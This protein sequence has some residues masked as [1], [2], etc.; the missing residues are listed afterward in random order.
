MGDSP[1][2]SP[3]LDR[4]H[5]LI[6]EWFLRNVGTPTDIQE[7]AWP[8]IAGGEHVLVSA[9]TGSGKTLT[10]FLWAVNQMV[11][12]EWEVGRGIRALYI[13]PLKALNNDINRNLSGPL[14][15]LRQTFEAA[16]EPFPNIRVMTRSGDTP[17]GERSR[18]L[19]RPPDILITTPESLN[20]L[21]TSRRGRTIFAP[22]NSL[23]LSSD[24]ATGGAD[25]PLAPRIGSVRTVILDEIHAVAGS[26]RGTHLITAIERLTELTGEFQRIALS[27]TVRPLEA[28][29]QFVGGYEL[30]SELDS[31][32]HSELDSELQGEGDHLT[33]A[34][35]GADFDFR[36]RPV[37]I[38]ETRVP[39]RI[40]IEVRSPEASAPAFVNR[41]DSEHAPPGS[42]SREELREDALEDVPEE[43]AIWIALAREFTQIIARNRS[44]LFF[45]NSRRLAEKMTRLI[46]QESGE[47]LALCHHGSL[48]REIRLLVE[49]RLKSGALRAIVAT[50]SLELGIDIGSVDEVVM[51]QTPRSVAQTLQRIGRAGH[52]VGQT[53][54]GAIYPA[55]NR[56]V[57]DAALMARAVLE[58]AIEPVR[59]PR[60]PLDVIAQVI[61][62]MVANQERDIEEVYARIR[63][64][65][66]CHGLERRAFD[67]VLEMLA[68]RY[69]DS[70]IRELRPRI[71]ID[72]VRGRIR[73]RENVER[74]LYMSGGTIPDRGYFDLRVSESNAKIGQL[75]EEF[76]WERAVGEVFSLGNHH[77]KIVDITHN[78]VLVTA[79]DPGQD[80]AIVPFW[81]ADQEDRGGHFCDRL[82]DFLE[83]AEQRLQ[84]AGETA[85]G[86]AATDA[87]GETPPGIAHA[88]GVF[89][90][91][92]AEIH[93]GLFAELQQNYRL[94]AEPAARLLQWL[95]R[96]REATGV[97][98]PGRRNLVVEY[99]RD[100]AGGGERLQVILH[101]FWGGRCNRPLALAFQAAWLEIHGESI[102]AIHNDDAVMLILPGEVPAVRLFGM[103]R[104][105]R[106]EEYLRVTLEPGGFFGARFRENAGRALLLP[107][108]GFGQRLPLWLN[109]LR[110]K[111]LL[112]AIRRYRD[113]PIL[114]ETWRSCFQESFEIDR[115]R[116]LLEDVQSGAIELSESRTRAASPFAADLVWRD[117]NVYMY[118]DDAARS[119]AG[120]GENRTTL[121]EQL[122]QEVVFS[123]ERRPRIAEDLRREFQAKLQRTAPGYAP[124]APVE[125][126]EWVK[127]R[128]LIPVPEWQA[129]L[130]SI[131]RD[132]SEEGGA[133]DSSSDAKET[134]KSGGDS[135]GQ[136]HPRNIEAL[137]KIV[138]EDLIVAVLPG[139]GIPVVLAAETLGRI[140][141]DLAAGAEDSESG[142]G[143]RGLIAQFLRYYGPVDPTILSLCFGF[144]LTQRESILKDLADSRAIVCAPLRKENDELC[145]CD[146]ENLESLLRMTRRRARPQIPAL[147]AR[148]LPAFLAEI[149]KVSPLG[150]VRDLPA[151]GAV[152]SQA[153]VI[154]IEKENENENENE[155]SSSGGRPALETLQ[156]VLEQLMGYPAEPGAWEREILP[157]RVSPYYTSF[158]DTL[159][160]EHD[161]VWFGCHHSRSISSNKKKDVAGKADIAFAFAEDLELY[162]L[163]GAMSSA[164]GQVAELKLSRDE[165]RLFSAL[166]G[167]PRSVSELYSRS[168]LEPETLSR[169][170]WS[171]A[172]RGL[173]SSD[174]FGVVRRGVLGRF[175]SE[176]GVAGAGRR[177]F[178]GAG[179]S[180]GW[181]RG[182]TR[183]SVRSGG[184]W[185]ALH[186]LAGPAETERDLYY[187][188]GDGSGETEIETEAAGD[189]AAF[190]PEPDLL[191]REELIRERVRILFARYGVL[192]R[193]LLANEAP[194]LRWS[195]VFRQL[196]LMEL[197]GEILGGYFFEGVPGLQFISPAANRLLGRGVDR[198]AVYGLSAKD[199]ASL[200]GIKSRNSNFRDLNFPE[201]K[202]GVHFVF[203]GDGGAVLIVRRKLSALEILCAPEDPVLPIA[204]RYFAR[205]MSRDFQ[206]QG[207]VQVETINERPALKSEYR[208]ALVAFGFESDFKYLT[209]RRPPG[210]GGL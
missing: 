148:H 102:Q 128:V 138:R 203:R 65:H 168:G 105:D 55:H 39:K 8:A 142:Q 189:G 100:P 63:C 134:N 56:D 111:K 198:S 123:G 135:S 130:E 81:R 156:A 177:R 182:A 176:G 51:I 83:Y 50:G 155:A 125:I 38:L 114:L 11:S 2:Y 113:F 43:D 54:R 107:P 20:I 12:G 178:G 140:A 119:N 202:S 10:A 22:E 196:R 191:D 162:G 151:A 163:S 104:S 14:L 94:Q 16:G 101:T 194:L 29:A 110:S 80:I 190:S 167:G 197:S 143:S 185:F 175:Q 200:A 172:W 82:R 164:G 4:F 139:G 118:A 73:G 74:V 30:H 116:G 132:L 173:I 72:R 68:G 33:A 166:S 208:D 159:F 186:E 84:E 205:L 161:L 146:A 129:L 181:S 192:F 188:A 46:N 25:D 88:T 59:P 95:A 58:R 91:S 47:A 158:L 149:Q 210:L 199:P 152:A 106:L 27:A 157:A 147:P 87:P 28:V 122:L 35:S 103:L 171:L 79:G 62:S 133:P 183:G 1:D 153:A 92:G 75:D 174:H 127:D 179:R 121:D 115:L 41:G 154:A 170:L 57:L 193:E 23:E 40:E 24:L 31:G 78:D 44:T 34:G 15:Q 52:G 26:R 70:R 165:E 66:S 77:W 53:S 160:Q 89:S 5:P 93:A 184:N 98:L 187:D 6:R 45:T 67:L 9:P 120:A 117:T 18:M 96:Q 85:N 49:E 141:D 97:A 99:F 3:V 17:A 136:E 195:E 19:R 21:L 137:L 150:V 206:A 64:A 108:S 71:S 37:R 76:V 36:A 201:R 60:A 207:P 204:L 124:R 13:S 209:L 7:Q 112:A 109:R 145:I 69:A 61:V 180:R 144:S 42:S 86:D 48:S 131:A 126:L 169:L 90:V 32:L